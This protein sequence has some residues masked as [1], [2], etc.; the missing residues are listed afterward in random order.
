MR[1]STIA[2][3]SIA[4]ILGAIGINRI[5]VMT[6]P[7][8][9][10]KKKPRMTAL[11]ETQ[12]LRKSNETVILQ[13]T[14][15]VIPAEQIMLRARVGGE[16]VSMSPGFIEGGLLKKE[17]EIL[18]I[19]PVDYQLA[20]AAAESKLETA[21]FNHK[22]E[23][24]RQDV[25][26]REW[27]LLKTDDASEQE[28]ELA[29]RIPH[30]AAS[31]A[32]LQA[33][34]AS[35]EKARIDLARTQIHAPFNAV[36]LERNVNVGSQATP[37]GQLARLAGTDAYWIKVS[38]PVDRLEW[39]D[40][41]GSAVKVLSNT[42]ANAIREGRVIKLLGDL[43]ERGRMA[44]LLVKV[45]DP[46][47]LQPENADKTALLIGEFVRAE[48]S[49][50]EENNVYSIPRNALHENRFIWIAQDDKLDIREVD[51]LWRDANQVL[52]RNGITDG[53]QLIVSD[54]TTPIQ[55]VDINTGKKKDKPA[56]T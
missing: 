53:D 9:E 8:A 56:K 41:P 19:D 48:I 24:G 34:K 26:Q 27:E 13:L 22:M 1:K 25:A 45:Q 55:G 17:D 10:K 38:I 37:A 49:G 46:L 23:L 20:L 6:A 11:V 40:I 52:V 51:V 50:R 5:L 31:K 43:E 42:N 30:L 32:A 15:T 14:G 35:E 54:M 39:L 36:V 29:L 47:C 3:I 33:A 28:K 2:I 16:I 7:K 18:E 21:R 12:E 44:R 4:L